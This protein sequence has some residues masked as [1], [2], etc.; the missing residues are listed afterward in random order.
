MKFK[1]NTVFIF[2]QSSKRRINVTTE[3][4]TDCAKHRNVK[5]EVTTKKAE[6]ATDCAKHRNVKAEV[7][8]VKTKAATDCAKHRNVK[9]EVTTGK[10][11]AATGKAEQRNLS[12]HKKFYS[13]DKYIKSAE[14]HPLHPAT[15]KV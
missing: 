7:A 6:A 9:A 14:R 15:S 3:A 5:A 8:T 2:P 13:N 12:V 10:A 11:E 1:T 4:A